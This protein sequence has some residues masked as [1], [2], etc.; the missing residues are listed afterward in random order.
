[1]TVEPHTYPTEEIQL[2][3]IPQA[4]PS[5]ADLERNARDQARVA[6]VWKR[7]EGPAKFDLP[8]GAPTSAFEARPGGGVK[9]TVTMGTTVKLDVHVVDGHL[10]TE[11]TDAGML[12]ENATNAVR[13]W[14]ND[15][16]NVLDHEGKQ[17]DTVELRPDGKVRMTKKAKAPKPV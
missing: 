8:L 3:D 16:N 5:P 4:N 11:V 10:A 7:K 13:D 2:P 12:G 14:T 6:K 15:F 17:L 9:V 1:M